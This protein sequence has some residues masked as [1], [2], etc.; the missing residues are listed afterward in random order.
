VEGFVAETT[1]VRSL[2]A[3]LGLPAEP[4]TFTARK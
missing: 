3:T 1:L 4:A 2:L